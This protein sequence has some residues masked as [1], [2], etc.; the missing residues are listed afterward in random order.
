[1]EKDCWERLVKRK[2][3]SELSSS[4]DSHE[5]LRK[6]ISHGRPS[7]LRQFVLDLAASHEDSSAMVKAHFENTANHEE[8]P[9]PTPNF[10]DRQKRSLAQDRTYG[11]FTIGKVLGEGGMGTVFLASR[12]DDLQLQV[13]LKVLSRSQSQSIE[14]FKKECCILS[15]L[16]HPSIAHLIDAGVLPSGLPWLAMEY[17][18]GMMLHQWLEDEQPDLERKLQLFMKI[19]DAVSYAHHRMIIHCDIKPGNIMVLP[20]DKPKLLDFGIASTLNPDTGQQHTQTQGFHGMMTFQYASPEQVKGLRLSAASDVYSLGMVLYEMLTGSLPYSLGNR[21]VDNIRI[22]NANE[23]PPPAS[24]VTKRTRLHAQLDGDLGAIILKML[25]K[26]LSRRYPDVEALVDD[27]SNYFNGLPVTARQ[28]T[29]LYRLNRFVYRNIQATIATLGTIFFLL[30]FSVYAWRQNIIMTREH[31]VLMEEKHNT[32]QVTD[33][34]LSMFE[35]VPRARPGTQVSV[36]Q[37]METGRRQLSHQPEDAPSLRRVAATMG[38]VYRSLGRYDRSRDL[39]SMAIEGASDETFYLELELVR[40]FHDAFDLDAAEKKLEELERDQ[41]AFDKRDERRIASLNYHWGRHWFLKG[42]YLDAENAYSLARQHFSVLTP[43]QQ[44]ALNLDHAI[45]RIQLGEI[46]LALDLLHEILD[47]K[48]ALY[49]R[50]HSEVAQIQILI[51]EQSARQGNFESTLAIYQEV[52]Q[53]TE[54]LFGKKHPRMIECYLKQ[55]ALYQD[56]NRF[57]QAAEKLANAQTLILESFGKNHILYADFISQSGL[58]HLRQGR[59]QEAEALFRQEVALKR[60]IFNKNNPEIAT[61]LSMLATCHAYGGTYQTAETLYREALTILTTF[62]GEKHPQIAHN[63]TNLGN[64][65]KY[66]ERPEEAEQL[67]RQALVQRVEIYGELHLEVSYPLYGLAHLLIKRKDYLAAEPLLRKVVRIRTKAYGERHN[68]VARAKGMLARVLEHKGDN[69]GAESLYRDHFMT[70]F[71]LL[72]E[73]HPALSIPAANLGK[74]LIKN[75][76][77]REA[78]EL[79]EKFTAIVEKQGESSRE[80]A[81]LLQVQG[82]L[83]MEKGAYPRAEQTLFKAK[84]LYVGEQRAGPTSV[85]PGLY[86]LMGKVMFRSGN[87]VEAQKYLN[88]AMTAGIHRFSRESME[89]V[90]YRMVLVDLFCRQGDLE[91]ARRELDMAERPVEKN[92]TSPYLTEI[93]N[94]QARILRLEGDPTAAET[95][96]R[97]VL[98]DYRTRRVAPTRIATVL[99][100]L[101]ETLTEAGR[102]HEAYPLIEE[103]NAIFTNNLPSTHEDHWTGMSVKGY[104]LYGMNHRT[105]GQN[106]LRQAYQ[107]LSKQQGANHWRTLEARK[108]LE[109][110][111]AL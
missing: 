37:V 89:L 21:Y 15:S 48:I 97:R 88:E 22:I 31:H 55:A 56:N 33:F 42:K 78:E 90:R 62:Y 96:Y 30:T 109:K 44:D 65:L 58:L 68:T 70:L 57:S 1:M 69:Q 110:V 9:D 100:D 86:L 71:D 12:N 54:T 51:G 98:T 106:L 39:L 103:A 105:E 67:L 40:T 83:F 29:L 64:V 99:A 104:I 79:L 18:E 108:R 59:Q 52:E 17:V 5:T 10:S 49:G 38:S 34:M 50:L 13:A 53:T 93:L 75:G 95:L 35:Q 66:L 107:A 81:F 80:L 11:P 4:P 45:L 36:L 26:D 8:Y 2:Y 7:V 60:K 16:R 27:L 23:I 25:E 76:K 20:G 47:R 77:L 28:T 72:G 111:G 14:L 24:L 46:D 84:N 82:M 6:L 85:P 87:L 92:E 3:Q 74:I 101:A 94:R 91:N 19:C 73:E 61:S 63:L 32:E 43:K 102:A 41:T